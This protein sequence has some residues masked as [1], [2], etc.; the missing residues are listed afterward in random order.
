MEFEELKNG[1]MVMVCSPADN[2]SA[3]QRTAWLSLAFV[4][5]GVMST[6]AELLSTVQVQKGGSS[7]LCLRYQV[8]GHKSLYHIYENDSKI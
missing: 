7:L 1:L 2:A 6:F 4:G 3:S 5:S 8:P